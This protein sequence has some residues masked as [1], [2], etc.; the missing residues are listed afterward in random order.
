MFAGFACR[1]AA[2]GPHQLAAAG[3]RGCIC[4]RLIVNMQLGIM[5]S[6][7]LDV[8]I[9]RSP[10]RRSCSSSSDIESHEGT[11]YQALAQLLLFRYPRHLVGLTAIRRCRDTHTAPGNVF[12]TLEAEA[13]QRL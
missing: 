3:K 8:G 1:D 10:L 7:L 6:G 13:T 4:P 11:T 9:Q 2:S 5:E 12:E